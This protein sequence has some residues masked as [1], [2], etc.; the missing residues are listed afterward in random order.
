[1]KWLINKLFLRWQT[2]SKVG[3]SRV[4]KTSF[5]WLLIVPF[6]AKLF[7]SIETISFNFFG[8]D[9]VLDLTLSFSFQMLFFSAIFATI[10][11]ILYT[12]YAPTLI[13]NYDSYNEFK[14][15]GKGLEQLKVEYKFLLKK[16]VFI[17]FSKNIEKMI[18]L[19]EKLI[20]S[21]HDST[22]GFTPS[23]DSQII[24]YSLKS[25]DEIAGFKYISKRKIHETIDKLKVEEEK[26]SQL[27][28]FIR[29][30][31][32]TLSPWARFFISIFY[33]ISFVILGLIAF[34]N[35]YYVTTQSNLDIFQ[36]FKELFLIKDS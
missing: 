14:E 13:S 24:E 11:Q 3:N 16:A 34:E 4:F 5:I 8:K 29:D 7:H 27:F 21:F 31:V 6:F 35:I 19:T 36:W 30:E 22:Q 15:E 10:G 33:L 25:E 1:M 18:N 26:Q 12:I 2:L 9:Y 32:D 17:D 28:W 23:I 20:E